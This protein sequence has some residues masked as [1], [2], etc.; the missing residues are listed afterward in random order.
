MVWL[1]RSGLVFGNS[2][3]AATVVLSSFMGGLALGNALVGVFGSRLRPFRTYASL[4]L[5]VA[6]TGV[7]LTVLLPRL[8]G[9]AVLLI[10]SSEVHPWLGNAARFVTAFAALVVPA[11]AMGAT[12]PLLSGALARRTS[13]VGVAVGQLYGWNTAGAVAGVLAAEVLLIQ[14]VGIFGTACVAAGLNVSAAALVLSV[15]RREVEWSGE[16]SDARARDGTGLWLMWAALSG[17][18]FLALEV[19]WFRFLSMYVLTT[20]LAMGLLLAV[21][22]AAIAGGG[23]IASVWLR[24][25]RHVEARCPL[26]RV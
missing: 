22:L 4:E 11:T 12:L 23:L 1:H 9:I 19:V 26:S 2:I 21:V 8:S 7:A 14:W 15:A 25:P 5:V 20:T 24:R 18:S 16:G 13:T 10:P 17:L 6:L 3:D